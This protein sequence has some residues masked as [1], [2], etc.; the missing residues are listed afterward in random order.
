MN[1]VLFKKL[2]ELQ[3]LLQKL[4][5]IQHLELNRVELFRHLQQYEHGSQLPDL[6]AK[7][8]KLGLVH[9][10]VYKVVLHYLS[11]DISGCN[12]RYISMF[13]AFQ[14]A[15]KDYTVPPEIQHLQQM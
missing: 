8:F 4:K 1:D 9:P 10:S 15:I 7:F 11:G 5:E 14:D 3:R 13:Q 6:E 12:A 2:S